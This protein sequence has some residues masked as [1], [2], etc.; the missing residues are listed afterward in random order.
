MVGINNYWQK[1]YELR[2][3]LFYLVKLDLK[4]KYRRSKLGILWSILYPAGLTIIMGIVFAVAF[5]YDVID[6]IPYVLSGILFWDLVNS[7]FSSGGYSLLSN[8]SF[9]RQCNH[10][11]TI[12]TLKSSFV[13]IINFLIAL[14]SLGIWV[15]VQNPLHL[16]TGII[17][18]PL[19]L[20]I[21]FVFVWGSTTIAGYTCVQYRDYPMMIPL[22]LQV[23]WYVS[24]VFFQESLFKSNEIIYTWFQWNPITHMLNLIR[25]PFLY[26]RFPSIND[27]FISVI[28]VVIVGYCAYKINKKK[29][30]DIIFYL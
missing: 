10:P 25:E 26:G 27:Y 21:F 16:I 8:D 9:I 22:I 2:Y 13:T 23:A 14:I 1:I 3:F 15:I 19:T 20:L 7:S 18:L 12:Y 24:P 11:L 4:N 28:L 17:S 5:K 29:E 6:Y 30:K